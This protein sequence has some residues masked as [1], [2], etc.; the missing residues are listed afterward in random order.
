M[1]ANSKQNRDPE[2]PEN[3]PRV[4][5][6][7]IQAG[8]LPLEEGRRRTES[9][10][11]GSTSGTTQTSDDDGHGPSATVS[12][13]P[14][15]P[16]VNGKNHIGLARDTYKG[17]PTTLCAGCGHNAITNHIIRAFYEYG[18]EPYQLAKMSGIGCSSKAPAYFVSQSHGF[19]SVH[20]RMPSVAT[21]AQMGDRGLVG[22]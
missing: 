7:Q 1:S 10:S 19:N 4:D 13:T 6:S 16:A 5:A 22:G 9:A 14:S 17:A 12:G 3:T 18:V 2:A 21:G 20:G 8:E 11:R 15:K